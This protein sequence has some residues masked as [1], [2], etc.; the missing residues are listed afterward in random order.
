LFGGWKVG[1]WMD[2]S[3]SCFKELNAFS[4][5]NWLLLVVVVEN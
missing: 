4:V 2:I 5:F 3:E 1:K